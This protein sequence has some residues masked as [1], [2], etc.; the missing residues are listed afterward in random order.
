MRFLDYEKVKQV[1]RE[2]GRELFGTAEEPTVLTTEAGFFPVA[3]EAKEQ[4]PANDPT[5]ILGRKT[6]SFE[7]STNGSAESSKQL[8]MNLTDEER[9]LLEKKINN[10]TS[11]KEI[12]ALEK[13]MKEGKLPSGLHQDAMEE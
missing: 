6:K 8:R 9:Q 2:K 11:L 7:M 5:Q 13:E 10:A 1:E 4:L 3:V 12:I